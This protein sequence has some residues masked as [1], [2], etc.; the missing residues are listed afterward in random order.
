MS[1]ASFL[2]VT[3]WGKDIERVLAEVSDSEGNTSFGSVL[4][5]DIVTYSRTDN[6][7]ITTTIPFKATAN[8]NTIFRIL[9]PGHAATL[10]YIGISPLPFM[11]PIGQVPLERTI[12]TSAIAVKAKQE[13]VV[14]LDGIPKTH[15]MLVL[16]DFGERKEVH[17]WINTNEEVEDTVGPKMME[18]GGETWLHR[19][20]QEGHPSPPP[21]SFIGSSTGLPL[22]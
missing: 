19:A 6:K 21:V 22:Y 13:K 5:C 16:E 17:H 8:A 14:A 4:T 3:V 1:P 12:N 18:L 20:F 15:T 2:Q 9:P 7:Y 10:K 11:T